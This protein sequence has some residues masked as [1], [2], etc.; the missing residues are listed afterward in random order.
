VNRAALRFERY[1][2]AAS[3]EWL[4]RTGPADGPA[5]LIVPPLFEEMNRTRALIAGVMRALA[6]RGIGAALPDL[7]GTGESETALEA[8]DWARWRHDVM[9]AAAF[10]G[11]RHVAAVRGGCLLDDAAAG[12][13]HWRFA[14]VA[15]ASLARDL[16]RAALA[17]GGDYAGYPAPE[18]LRAALKGAVAAGVAPLRTVRLE[19]DAQ[20]AD[21]RVAGPALWRR[22]EPGTSAALADALAADLAEWSRTCAG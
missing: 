9:A 15:G 12:A 8:A 14:P 18:A 10:V 5:L 17:G 21:A 11:A 2:A 19:S 20:P 7:S 22:S 13:A 4:M 3:A 1:P 16:E 6:A